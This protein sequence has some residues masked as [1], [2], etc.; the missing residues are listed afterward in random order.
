MHKPQGWGSFK[1]F[2][3]EF[4]IHPFPYSIRPITGSGIFMYDPNLFPQMI[5]V[6]RAL[7]LL[8]SPPDSTIL[9]GPWSG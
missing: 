9:K 4:I 7:S 1:D 3:L 5:L 2:L 6:L 8:R